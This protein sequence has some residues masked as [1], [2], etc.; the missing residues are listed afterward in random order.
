[1]TDEDAAMINK[2]GMLRTMALE[3][4][5][6][7]LKYSGE[8]RPDVVAIAESYYNFMSKVESVKKENVTPFKQLN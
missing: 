3:L 6:E 7:N 4:A 8:G 2:E 1:M 5:M